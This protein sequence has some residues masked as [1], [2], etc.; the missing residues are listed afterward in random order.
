MKVLVLGASGMLGSMVTQVLADSRNFDVYGAM[1][2]E[3]VFSDFRNPEL[4]KLVRCNDILNVI[5]LTRIFG[6]VQ[7]NI[8]INCIGLVKQLEA[9]NDPL[10]TI[11]I[12]S[13]LPHQLAKLCL[14]HNARLVHISTDC[15]FSGAK[16]GYK[17]EDLADARDLYGLSKYLGEVNYPNAITLR[18]SIIG[19]ELRTN[20]SLINWF[21]SQNDKCFG[22]EKAIYS[23]VPTVVL[24]SIIRDY[25][26]PNDKLHGLYHVSSSSISKYELLR[27]VARIYNKNIEI[28]PDTS[29][30][31][32]RSLNCELFQRATGYMPASWESMIKQMH[33]YR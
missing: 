9:V 29:L 19:H 24:A 5:E 2:N 22:Y 30:V 20:H 28:I 14:G 18:T 23:G 21:L 3:V 16:G 33:D 15:V 31:I 1:R 4:I 13:L 7:P 32:D 25:V 6:E 8:V 26:L 11:P 12:N 10:N 17:E 27:L